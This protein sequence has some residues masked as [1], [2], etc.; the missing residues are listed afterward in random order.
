MQTDHIAYA[1]LTRH[2]EQGSS[3]DEIVRWINQDLSETSLTYGYF[4]SE[5]NRI[6]NVLVGLGIQPADIISIFL[7]R[8]PS[9]F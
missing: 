9:P 7:P 5:S 6:A 8:S 2:C 1:C 3:D 4:E